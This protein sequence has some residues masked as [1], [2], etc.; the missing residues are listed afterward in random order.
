MDNK[1]ME[2]M[3]NTKDPDRV[4]WYGECLYWTDDWGDFEQE[5]LP[6]CPHCGAKGW[7]IKFRYWEKQAK[8]Y[9]QASPKNACYWQFLRHTKRCCRRGLGIV[10]AFEKWKNEH[11]LPMDTPEYPPTSN[12][13]RES[14]SDTRP[15]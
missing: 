1:D 6:R 10:E 15:E 8:A 12:L 3:N 5:S 13:N 2:R 14:R 11:L 9:E 4:V 7:T